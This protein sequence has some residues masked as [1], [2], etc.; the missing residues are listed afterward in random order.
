MARARKRKLPLS[1]QRISAYVTEQFGTTRAAAEKL[2][3]AHNTIWRA[4][5][6]HNARGPS[7]DLA[8]A[9]AEHSGKPTDY[10]LG[11]AE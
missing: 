1:A 2:K 7:S 9:L 3:I 6:G 11:R 4:M 5:N 10:W 8:I